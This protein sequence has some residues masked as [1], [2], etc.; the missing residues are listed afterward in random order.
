M[1]C[2]S[3]AGKAC[4]AALAVA[5]LFVCLPGAWALGQRGGRGR[6]APARQ[7]SAPRG[8]WNRG[9]ENRNFGNRNVQNRERGQNQNRGQYQ[10][11]R[12]E[13]P[14]FARWAQSPAVQR[15]ERQAERNAQRNAERNRGRQQNRPEYPGARQGPQGYPGAGAQREPQAYPGA[16]QRPQRPEYRSPNRPAYPGGNDSS[17]GTGAQV[18]QP[19]VYPSLKKPGHLQDWLNKHR[20]LSIQQQE[21]VLSRDP[22]FKALPPGD[23]QR[24]MQQLRQVDRMPRAQRELRL[25]RNEMIERLSPEQQMQVNRSA[26]QL[27]QLP[28]NRE[29]LVKQAFQELRS[30]PVN[31]RQTVLDSQRYQHMF[32]PEERGILTNLLRVEPYSPPQ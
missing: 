22:T 25:A 4:A 16:G 8:N 30:V 17:A 11:R 14:S 2:V 32:T 12:G 6:E 19:Y 20:G 24:L 31:Q 23:Q 1:T 27:R 5:A 13:N 9:Y 15:A 7:Y 28:A 29:A 3:N 21:R 10:N 18:R 26:M